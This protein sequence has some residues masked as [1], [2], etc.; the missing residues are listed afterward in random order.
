MSF[1][2]DIDVSEVNELL[3]EAA[4]GVISWLTNPTTKSVSLE[5]PS[6]VPDT[7]LLTSISKDVLQVVAIDLAGSDST[8]SPSG[9]AWTA[10]RSLTKANGNLN[11]FC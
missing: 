7:T 5:E 6:L 10:A 2:E 9:E 1:N 11:Y 3:K 8:K 4:D